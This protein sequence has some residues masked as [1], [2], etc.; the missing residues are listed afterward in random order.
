M[1]REQSLLQWARTTDFPVPI[2]WGEIEAAVLARP[3]PQDELANLPQPPRVPWVVVGPLVVLVHASAI[4]GL[5]MVL[6]GTNAS[7]PAT[8]AAWF[9]A[10]PIPFVIAFALVLRPIFT[11]ADT[12]RRG[13]WDLLAVGVTGAASL[14]AY[15]VLLAIPE[16]LGWLPWLVLATAVASVISFVVLL[17]R[18]RSGRQLPRARHLTPSERWYQ[19]ARAQVLEVLLSRGLIDRR[20][21]DVTGMV[22]MPLGS[23]R[24]LDMPGDPRAR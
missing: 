1:T 6:A 13:R 22:E 24:E 21:V 12:R 14:A 18:R 8:A 17:V 16:E 7:D 10:A 9:G 19:A 15:L 23:W 2:R 11:S 3:V 4:L 5:A 20:E